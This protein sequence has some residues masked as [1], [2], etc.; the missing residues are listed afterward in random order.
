MNPHTLKF[1]VGFNLAVALSLAVILFIG[2]VTWLQRN[3]LI[4]TD[5]S[6]LIQL[7]EAVSKSIHFAML[8]NQPAYVDT[9]IQD[10]AQQDQIDRIRIL[11][12][13]GE[14][15]H[16]TYFPELGETVDR[17]AEGCA[18]CHGA[19]APLQELPQNKRFWI[20]TTPAGQR[21]LGTM[22]VIRNEPS[23][24]T[25]A[26]HHHSPTTPVLG[27]LDIRYSL[28]DMDHQLRRTTLTMAGLSLA[29]V[30]AASLAAALFIHRLVYLPLRDLEAG[31][32]RV[33]SGNLEQSIPVRGD[34]E[35]GTLAKAFNA[36]TAALRNSRAELHE[37][38]RTLEQK[39][40][41]R[42][43]QLQIAQAEAAR[44]EKL[45]S[46][47]L[48]ASG[49]AHELNNPLTGVLTFSV[50]LR[51]KMEDGSPD[52][53]DMDLVIRETRRCASIIKRL[54]DFAREKPP[55]K[56][57]AD[58]NQIIQET[59]RIVEPPANLRNIAIRLELDPNLPPAWADPDQIK[60]V[61]LNLLVN[62]QHAIDANGSITIRTRASPQSLVGKARMIEMSVADT[63]CGIPPENLKRIFDPFFTTKVAVGTGLGLSVSHSIAEA[64]GGSIDVDSEVGKG[65]TFRVRL[66]LMEAPVP[67]EPVSSGEA[68]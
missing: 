39:V 66:P 38:A 13:T 21:M 47:G 27:V 36:M 65:S 18:T 16:T 50:L 57:Y 64:H 49:I 23:C 61:I 35:F 31:A 41:Q 1:K 17:K 10:V 54:L 63:G 52:A 19:G 60:Q 33:S 30:A 24:A 37:W 48:L 45:A 14:I 29:F 58:L 43:E 8:Q 9:I 53:E 67:A 62:A 40:E 5:A 46:V 32:R 7:S 20:F 6:H 68:L 12:K 42:T 25:A 51:E 28:A 44:S 59:V 2:V 22:Q 4:D 56:K 11:D 3:A 34:D 15:T 55:E 26:C